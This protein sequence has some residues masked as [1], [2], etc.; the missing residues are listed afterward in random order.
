MLNAVAASH[1]VTITTHGQQQ[2]SEDSYDAGKHAA[3]SGL[4]ACTPLGHFL[5]STSRHAVPCC[6]S[7]ILWK[8]ASSV[9]LHNNSKRLDVLGEQT[10]FTFT[11][12]HSRM[13]INYSSMPKKK[14]MFLKKVIQVSAENW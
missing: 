5:C 4:R 3:S 6:T 12:M 8:A 13:R 14:R 7:S 9:D 10:R 2:R 11:A 1:D